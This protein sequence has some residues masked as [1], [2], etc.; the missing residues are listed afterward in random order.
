MKQFVLA[1]PLDMPTDAVWP[2]MIQHDLMAIAPSGP[3][4]YL[5][6]VPFA[7]RA[8]LRSAHTEL[9]E[10]FADHSPLSPE[11]RERLSQHQSILFLLGELND[12]DRFAAVQGTI[13]ALLKHGALGIACE[14]SGSAYT[15][16]E[17]LE[18]DYEE[19]MLGWLN[20]IQA[21]GD[22]RTFGMECFGL[23]DL[24]VSCKADEDSDTLQVVMLHVAED[25]FLEGIPL[26]TGNIVETGEGLSYMLR[27][28]PKQPWPKGHPNYN[29]KGCL[30]LVGC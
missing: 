11:D 14:H 8:H 4:L 3:E 15:A 18:G 29:A 19:T 7:F 10:I 21:K 13:H 12:A 16:Q 17:W 1:F 27:Q 25:L 30:R 28:E 22:L 6:G 20:W 24:V 9:V 26:Q 23:P 5:K 2:W